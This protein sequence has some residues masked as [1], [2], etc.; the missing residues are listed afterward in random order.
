LAVLAGE[1]LLAMAFE[2]IAAFTVGMPLARIVRGIGELVR[3]IGAEGVVGGQVF[4][5]SSK[6][7]LA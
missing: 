4:D 1:T 3:L 6:G 5:I 2:H 7:S